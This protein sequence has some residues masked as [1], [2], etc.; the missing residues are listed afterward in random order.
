[1]LINKRSRKNRGYQA[2]GK[3]SILNIQPDDVI[4]I[5][6]LKVWSFDSLNVEVFE[7]MCYT[8]Y[9]IALDENLNNTQLGGKYA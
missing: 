1:M 5:D 6:M 9:S 8:Y 7:M 4:R 2:F 3:L